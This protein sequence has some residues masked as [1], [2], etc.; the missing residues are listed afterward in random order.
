MVLL[1]GHAAVNA[2]ASSIFSLLGKRVNYYLTDEI[3]LKYDHMATKLYSE[4]IFFRT[5]HFSV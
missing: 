2:I 3:Y 1:V 5:D 4:I